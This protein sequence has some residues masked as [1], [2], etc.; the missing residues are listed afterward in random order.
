VVRAA[1]VFA[2]VRKNGDVDVPEAIAEGNDWLGLEVSELR[3][4]DREVMG[5]VRCWMFTSADAL[6]SLALGRVYSNSGGISSGGGI[7]MPRAA[8]M[9]WCSAH[10][11]EKSFSPL[12]KGARRRSI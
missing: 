2:R 4:C 8:A 5:T 12:Q 11:S 6:V 7:S 9:I 10:D 1:R 3:D